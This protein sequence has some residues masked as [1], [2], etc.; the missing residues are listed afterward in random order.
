MV[1][2]ILTAMV[3]IAQTPAAQE[4]LKTGEAR[5][6]YANEDFPFDGV[7]SGERVNVRM[8]NKGDMQI[9]TSIIAT[10]LASGE[11]VRVVAQKDDFFQIAPPR[12]TAVW[13]WARN[14]K[15]DADDFGTVVGSDVPVRLDSR[16]NA[17]KVAALGEGAK[18][19]ILRENLGWY[20]IAAPDTVKYWIAKKYVKY[21]AKGQPEAG[22]AAPAKPG[23][24][25]DAR[26]LF[27]DAKALVS[28]QIKLLNDSQIDKLDFGKVADAFEAAAAAARSDDMRKEADGQ[29][30]HWRRMQVVVAGFQK[31]IESAT[32]RIEKIKEEIRDKNRVEEP[33]WAFTGH[34]D[35][36]GR[37]WNRPGAHKLVMGGKIICFLKAKDGDAEMEKKLNSLFE[38]YVGVTGTVVKDVEG[39]PGYSVVIVESVQEVKP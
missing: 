15:K 7:V 33:K 20:Q 9:A 36:V 18:V 30:Q 27:D 31:G 34:V 26:A 21:E 10:V 29:A 22:I 28:E 37:L 11:K 4:G 1:T 23:A 8:F 16:A 24:D 6:A 12:G 39:W 38:K 19:K 2:G 32:A 14:V 35:T 25:A 13:I 5:T 3:L 17:D